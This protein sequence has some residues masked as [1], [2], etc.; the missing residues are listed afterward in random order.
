MN[1][2]AGCSYLNAAKFRPIC[3]HRLHS[4][5]PLGVFF[6]F[7]VKMGMHHY[8][9]RHHHCHHVIIIVACRTL[10]YFSRTQIQ[11]HTYGSHSIGRSNVNNAIQSISLSVLYVHSEHT[12]THTHMHALRTCTCMCTCLHRIAGPYECCCIKR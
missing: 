11:T 4:F 7:H 8:D 2:V 6:F 3:V 12:N 10:I 9:Q 1:S 5:I